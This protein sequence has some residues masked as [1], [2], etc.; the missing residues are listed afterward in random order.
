MKFTQ[1]LKS[2]YKTF[3][4]SACKIILQINFRRQNITN[5]IFSCSII[6]I[7]YV[8]VLY[9]VVEKAAGFTPQDV[10]WRKGKYVPEHALIGISM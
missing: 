9:I 8:C 10:N 7:V 1:K 5:R 2:I 4:D 3:P 6:I